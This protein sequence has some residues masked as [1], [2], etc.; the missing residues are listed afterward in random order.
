M[1]VKTL[2]QAILLKLAVIIIRPGNP[3]EE[4]DVKVQKQK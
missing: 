4:A 3:T 2:D 1:V